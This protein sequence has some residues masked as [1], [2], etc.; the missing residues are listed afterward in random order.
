MVLASRLRFRQVGGL[1]AGEKAWQRFSDSETR[2]SMRLNL[3]KSSRSV[4]FAFLTGAFDL[5][6]RRDLSD[7]DVL[8]ALV[9]HR[10]LSYFIATKNLLTCA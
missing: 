9:S 6:N 5:E 10:L 8:S 2:W 3:C 1:I 7:S 4:S